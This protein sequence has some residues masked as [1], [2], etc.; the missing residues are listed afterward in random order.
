MTKLTTGIK[1]SR[2]VA[3]KAKWLRFAGRAQ[4]YPYWNIGA[5]N[6]VEIGGFFYTDSTD[7]PSI[8]LG[9]G[10]WEYMG[11]GSLTYS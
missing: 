3:R 11:T 4:P 2:S 8:I 9:Y 1:K 6:T 10:T 7:D 5:G